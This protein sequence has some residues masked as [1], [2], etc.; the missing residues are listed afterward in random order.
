MGQINL[1]H[2]DLLSDCLADRNEMQLDIVVNQL[3]NSMGSSSHL[4]QNS[5]SIT[6]LKP[7]NYNYILVKSEIWP[8]YTRRGGYA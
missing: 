8:C 2:A 3:A 5:F 6:S 7:V 1:M 4:K